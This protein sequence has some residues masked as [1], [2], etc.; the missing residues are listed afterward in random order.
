MP[1]P[2]RD[3]EGVHA[4]AS[5]SVGGTVRHRDFG[6]FQEF[7]G[8]IEI[9]SIPQAEDLHESRLKTSQK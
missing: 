7:I 8:V 6:S 5:V 4:Q 1:I 3:W 2:A 9:V